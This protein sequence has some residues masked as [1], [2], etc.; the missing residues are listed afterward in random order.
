MIEFIKVELDNT[1]DGGISPMIV[2]TAE[3][4]FVAILIE[5]YSW[6][7]YIDSSIERLLESDEVGPK[8]EENG[9]FLN[10]LNK[11]TGGVK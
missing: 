5:I 7:K 9:V 3:L 2:S 11:D 10:L 8:F 4:F 1:S 6:V